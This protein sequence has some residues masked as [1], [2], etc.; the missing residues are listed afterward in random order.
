M[1]NQALDFDDEIT[2]E[3]KEIFKIIPPQFVKIELAKNP[4]RSKKFPGSA[5]SPACPIVEFQLKATTRDGDS[6][7]INHGIFWNTF[8][9]N[10][11]AALMLCFGWVKPGERGKI[12]WQQ[13]VGAKGFAKTGI[14]KGKNQ[15]TNKETG[16]LIFDQEGKPVFPDFMEIDKFIP[17]DTEEWE[18]AK[19]FV[20]SSSIPNTQEQTQYNPLTGGDDGDEF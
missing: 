20:E 13:A 11:I 12:P 9:Q 15:K 6:L 2:G 18:K 7:S 10:E 17:R 8:S 1:E 14:R 5:K 19:A 16:E 3:V 4:D